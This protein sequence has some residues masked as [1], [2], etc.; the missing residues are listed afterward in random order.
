VSDTSA[1]FFVTTDEAALDRNAVARR[2]IGT[3]SLD[4]AEAAVHETCGFTELDHERAK[5]QALAQSPERETSRAELR[6]RLDEYRISA[7][8]RG[9]DLGSFR[10]ITEVLGRRHYDPALIR[11]L[12]GPLAYDDLPLCQL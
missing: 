11:S 3:R 10:R 2:L 6:T 4:E 12:A 5:A 9:I 8:S 7:R 1:D